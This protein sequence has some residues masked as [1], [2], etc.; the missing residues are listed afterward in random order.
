MHALRAFLIAGIA[1]TLATAQTYTAHPIDNLASSTSQNIPIA[2]NS[3]SWDEARSQFLFLA[4]FL[5]PTGGLITALE[6]VP[7]TTYATPYERF[8]IW[9]DHTANTALSTTFANNLTSPQLVF[10]Q[11]P[12]SIAWVGNTWTTITLQ[13]PFVYD[14]ASN[15]VVEVR[16]KIDRPLN[17]PTTAVSHRVL[18]WPRRA[19]LPVPI[20]AYGM[21]GSGAVDAA[22]ATTTYNTQLLMRFVWTGLSTMRINST[23]DT[24]GNSS[25]AYFHLGATITVTTQGTPGAFHLDAIDFGLSP[26]GLPVPGVNGELWLTFGLVIYGSGVLDAGGLGST[27][28]TIPNNAALV[29]TRAYFQGGTIGASIDFTNVVDGPIAVF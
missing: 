12:G 9:M 17:P 26:A 21:Y 28:L 24:T 4:A 29:G 19:D 2:G 11:S 16:K 25:R 15:L 8:E 22:T 7:N 10:A 18:V 20:W 13:T 23:R 6:V 3:T 14:G 27:S 5:P 1:G